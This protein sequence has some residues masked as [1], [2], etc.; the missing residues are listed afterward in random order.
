ML[1]KDIIKEGIQTISALYPE[2][3]AREMVLAFLQEEFSTQ[4]HTHIICPDF[5]LSDQQT[6]KARKA[7]E[8]MAAG[9]PLQYVLGR[10]W[11]YGRKF[12][13]SP[14][15]LI[16]RPETE[17]LCREAIQTLGHGKPSKVIDL[18]TGSGCIGWT[19][20]A[21]CPQADVVA[22][23]ISQDALDVATS[24]FGEE[25]ENRPAFYRFDVLAAPPSDI[26][27]N[28][29]FDLLLSNPPYVMD[30]EKALMRKNVLEH[31]PELALFVPD[32]DPLVFY[33][34]IAV[35]A[36]KLLK[37]GGCVVVEINEALGK[38]TAEIFERAG[39]GDVKIVKDLSEK[40]R[41]V[42]CTRIN[43]LSC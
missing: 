38:E 19:M 33:R 25:I 22:V 10:A 30:S 7:F 2:G 23:D 18:C 11:F 9:E 42:R 36:G 5:S 3:E 40:E 16:P 12:N 15:V 41:F 27:E 28:N 13:V 20:A 17:I 35:W 39:F 34:A 43:K 1:L 31:E 26:F 6:S 21:E 8:R 14:S 24:Q 37:E 4:R 29:S 32:H